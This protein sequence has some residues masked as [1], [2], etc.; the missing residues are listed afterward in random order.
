MIAM[1]APHIT[2]IGVAAIGFDC[3][4]N[5]KDDI[6]VALQ[7]LHK[8]PRVIGQKTGHIVIGIVPRRVDG[9]RFNHFLRDVGVSDTHIDER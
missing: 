2:D 9:E 6:L 7:Q 1:F 8:T 4:H 5:G 3:A